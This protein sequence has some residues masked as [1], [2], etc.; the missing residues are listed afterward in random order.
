MATTI[1]RREALKRTAAATAAGALSTEAWPQQTPRYENLTAAEARTLE[2]VVARLIPSD[3]RGPGAAEAGAARYIDHALGGALSASYESYRLG[4][5]ALDR[6]AREA[7]GA[8]FTSLPAEQQDSVLADLEANRIPGFDPDA[9]TF[10]ELVREHTL[11]GT[12]CDPAYRG[13]RDFVGWEMLGYPGL[14]LAVS[15][16]QQAMT[17]DDALTRLSAYDLPMFD[18]NGGPADDN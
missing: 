9:A 13:N 11:E 16:E 8:S 17:A 10:F 1:S 7:R 4:L 2:A 12:F 18:G 5:G 15:A 3:E 14:K 6:H